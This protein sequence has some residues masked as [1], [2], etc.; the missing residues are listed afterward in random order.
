MIRKVLASG[1]VRGVDYADFA[2]D[3]IAMQDATAQMALLQFM[4][5]GKGSS[6]VPAS[7]HCDHLIVARRGAEADL[8]EALNTNREIYDFLQSVSEKYN[9]DFWE[10]GSGIIHQIIT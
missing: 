7:V 1:Y 2:P 6:L 10:P 5:A 8:K 4:L 9:I 3:R